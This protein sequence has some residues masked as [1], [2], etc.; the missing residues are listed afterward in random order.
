MAK[1]GDHTDTTW[2]QPEESALSGEK[3]STSS[4]LQVVEE[5]VKFVNG[6]VLAPPKTD[7]M[8]MAKPIADQ[9]AAMMIQDMRGFLQGTEQILTVAIA[10]ALNQIL[11]SDGLI[12][13]TALNKCEELMTKLPVFASEIS[14]SAIQITKEFE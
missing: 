5:T 11:E 7:L 12:G 1:L 4:G 2:T 6:E 3:Q 8:N 9:A 14:E 10:R 13:T